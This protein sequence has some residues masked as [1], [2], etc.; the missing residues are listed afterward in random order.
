[1]HESSAVDP[2]DAPATGSD[3]MHVNHREADRIAGDFA[4]RRNERRAALD[5][6]DVSGRAADIERDHII[7]TDRV[8]DPECTHH[9][10]R[11][12]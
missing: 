6:A 1:M 11:G 2:R 12:T 3:R 7:E 9:S 4:L 5:E 8:R 10:R